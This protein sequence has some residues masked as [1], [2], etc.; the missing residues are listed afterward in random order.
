MVL[1]NIFQLIINNSFKSHKFICSNNI[2]LF[3][4]VSK[5][6]LELL[7]SVWDQYA[8]LGSIE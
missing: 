8:D 3:G 4:L 7:G 5:Q 1:F 6:I 2:S